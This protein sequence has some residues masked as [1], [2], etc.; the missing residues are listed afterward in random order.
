MEDGEG[1]CSAAAHSTGRRLRTDRSTVILRRATRHWRGGCSGR[2]SGRSGKSG[3]WANG[4]SGVAAS[5]GCT[6]LVCLELNVGQC[7]QLPPPWHEQEGGRQVQ[8]TSGHAASQQL[9][10]APLENPEADDL[11]PEPVAEADESQRGCMKSRCV[12]NT[13]LGRYHHG[14]RVQ[15]ICPNL[16]ADDG[17]ECVWAQQACPT[18]GPK[19]GVWS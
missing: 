14:C 19:T 8:L 12:G 5:A 9:T 1:G 11:N 16:T 13:T 3:S 6:A 15:R 7:A 18:G 17:L 2:R 4:T 10:A